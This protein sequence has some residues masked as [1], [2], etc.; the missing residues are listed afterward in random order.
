MD[1][2]DEA[3]AEEG[4]GSGEEGG[5]EGGEGGEGAVY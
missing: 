4:G 3:R 1:E 2:P 5:A